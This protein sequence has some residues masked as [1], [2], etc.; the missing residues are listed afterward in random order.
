MNEFYCHAAINRNAKSIL[1]PVAFVRR[2]MFENC[3]SRLSV[4]VL[5]V[6]L[7][8]VCYV[9]GSEKSACYAR[10]IT[11]GPFKIHFRSHVIISRV[12]KT[13]VIN[14]CCANTEK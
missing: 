4:Y 14:H 10:R 12:K 8:C 7:H 5:Y 2:F 13:D 6:H 3:H 11:V 9:V 1:V